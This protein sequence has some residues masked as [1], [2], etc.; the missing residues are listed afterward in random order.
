MSVKPIPEG[1]HTITPQLAVQD[2]GKT[3]VAH[4]GQAWQDATIFDAVAM[5]TGGPEFY[6]KAFGAEV[7]DFAKDPS[8]EKVWHA[9]LRIGTSMIY[10]NDVFPEM[11][12][13]ESQSS[14]WLYVAD[15]DAAF[16]QA[17]EAGAKALMPPGDMFW[18]DRMAHV[19]DPFNQTW[20][21]ATHVKDL[22]PEQ[23][24]AAEAEF[25]ANMK[26]E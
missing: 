19:A 13:R 6:K 23:L 10:V 3:A 5:S 1:Y 25:V 4:G 11:G 20:A 8:G 7:K 17:T 18:G 14:I 2:A 15:C 22:T 24:K 9:S 26:K 16:E 21:L 12:G